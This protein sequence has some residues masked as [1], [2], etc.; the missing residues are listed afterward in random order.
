MKAGFGLARALF[1]AISKI[2]RYS[3]YI[4][5]H[6]LQVMIVSLITAI[7]LYRPENLYIYWFDGDHS[8]NNID[9][10]KVLDFLARFSKKSSK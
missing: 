8:E 10:D 6:T 7:E 9:K 4:F 5:A 1:S 2:D 3:S